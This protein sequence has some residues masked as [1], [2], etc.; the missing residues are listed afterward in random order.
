VEA[1][2]DGFPTMIVF[3]RNLAVDTIIGVYEHERA[4]PMSLLLDLEIELSHGRAGET[5]Q[6]ADTIDY[7]AVIDGIRRFLATTRCRLLERL[8]EL[9]AT[10]VLD[11]FG[12]KRVSLQIA[13]IGMFPGVGHVG[14]RLECSRQ[15][16]G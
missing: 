14:V 10:F 12:A 16:R 15:D 11:E 8:A 6:L 2:F 4:K 3:I 1:V 13:K 9:V 7:G 5:D